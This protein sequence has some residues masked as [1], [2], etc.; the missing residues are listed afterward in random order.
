MSNLIYKLTLGSQATQVKTILPL[1]AAVLSI[2]NQ[3]DQV[4]LWYEF[5]PEQKELMRKLKSELQMIVSS[6]K[7]ITAM[8]E[9]AARQKL[10][11]LSL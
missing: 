9:S 4:V 2:Q 10:L 5:D 8:N 3:D 1:G 6:G 7:A 11:Q